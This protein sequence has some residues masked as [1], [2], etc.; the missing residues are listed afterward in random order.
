[1]PVASPLMS[2]DRTAIVA[3]TGLIGGS[4]GMALRRDGWHVTGL[5][6]D[7][8]RARTA[9]EVGA[10]DCIGGPG[11]CDLAVV[12]TPAGMLADTAKN[13]LRAGAGIVTDVDSVKVPVVR[14]VTDPRFIG[15]HPMAGNEQDGLAGA[16]P[17]LFRDAVWVLTPTETTEDAAL[18]AVRETISGFGAQVLS[19]TPQRHDALIAV[20]SHVPHLAAAALMR[21]AARRSNEHRA[22]LRL[23]AGGFRD[24]TRVAAGNP[25]IWPDICVENRAAIA[26]VLDELLDE[27]EEMRLIVSCGERDELLARLETARDSRRSLS[28]DAP[29][30][31][32]L[33]EVRV[34]VRDQKGELARITTLAAD[35]DVNI[36]DLEIAH[37]AEGP[38]GVVLLLVDSETAERFRHGLAETGYRPFLKPLE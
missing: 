6:P 15:G 3:G 19:L 29:E 21:I 12:A 28:G 2:R 18:A 20:V 13:L 24:M 4:V 35:L 37:S 34:A 31:S 5:E 11:P 17:D 7:T 1:M 14:A 25:A 33:T 10:V 8:Q 30:P 22:L 38:H 26:D 16:D 36:Y 27:L 9:I 32:H 23:A